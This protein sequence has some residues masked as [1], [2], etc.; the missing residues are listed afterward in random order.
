MFRYE[1]A[2][3]AGKTQGIIKSMLLG[4]GMGTTFAV[5]FCDYALSFYIG[6]NFVADGKSSPNTVLTVIIK[7]LLRPPWSWVGYPEPVPA[8]TLGMALWAPIPHMANF[9]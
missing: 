9:H 1:R 8:C 4:I 2:L 5:M 3:D 6:T 7:S